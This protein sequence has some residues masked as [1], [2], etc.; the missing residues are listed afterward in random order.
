MKTVDLVVVGGGPA[1]MAAATAGADFG[2]SVALIDD[3]PEPGG[4]V[5]KQGRR[6][7]AVR[8]TDPIEAAVGR[9]LARRFE[10]RRHRLS[11]FAD[12]EVW[13]VAA[14]NTLSFSIS[15]NGAQ[16][17]ETARGRCLIFCTGALERVIP[18]EGWHLPGV[19]SVG[20]LNT[21]V[22]RGV[23]PGRRFVV[24]GS[25]PL[26]MV[27]A[28]NLLQNGAKIEAL[29]TA[30]CWSRSAG[31]LPI[32]A[33]TVDPFK[34]AAAIIYATTLKRHRVPILTASAVTRAEGDAE[35][36]SVTVNALDRS[37]TPQPGGRQIPADVVAVSFGLIPAT[38]LTRL[39]GCGHVFDE[40]LGYWR[41]ARNRSGET[42][43]AGVFAAGDGVT[44]KG[45]AAAAAEG[46]AAAI[47]ACARLG[48]IDRP[49]ADRALAPLLRRLATAA[50]F[51]R[52]LDRLSQPR[53]GIFTAVSDATIV[54]RCEDVSAGDIRRA[55]AGG[56]RDVHE[57]KRTTRL[58][59]GP[60][61]GRFCGQVVN[62]LMWQANGRQVPRQ[63][64]TPRSP[65]RPVNF[66]VLADALN[67]DRKD[68]S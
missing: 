43:V 34:L 40:D 38:E 9:R 42:D 5:L 67:H 54:C 17:L 6:G 58:G 8:H 23:I 41:V 2:A 37:W 62:E 57:I 1:G 39:R 14:D 4:K 51:G 48:L 59:M 10:R 16:R 20:G 47:A 56:A 21:L 27:L 32:L 30:V 63:T 12:S 52:A 46:R 18:F 64:F 44:V 26:P 36:L 25:G 7:P 15:S 13:D 22:K 61:Q 68:R 66:G 35:R 24:G 3:S 19:Y 49:S 53:P 28:R 65:V 55:V 50:R 45:Y 60:C 11:I 33:A 29:A 31:R